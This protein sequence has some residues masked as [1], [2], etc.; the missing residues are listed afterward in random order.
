MTNGEEGGQRIT[1]IDAK[2]LRK[3]KSFAVIGVIRGQIR[4][5][6]FIRVHLCSFACHAVAT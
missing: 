3:R 4:S 2:I 1:R 5:V 6:C